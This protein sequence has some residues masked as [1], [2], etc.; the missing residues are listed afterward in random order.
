MPLSTKNSKTSKRSKAV[1]SHKKLKDSAFGFE[2][3][4]MQRGVEE[5][6]GSHTVCGRINRQRA[7]PGV[8]LTGRALITRRRPCY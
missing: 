2:T 4:T 6:L 7:K 3:A 1:F 8:K 5:P